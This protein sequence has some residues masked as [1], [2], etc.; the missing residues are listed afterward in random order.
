MANEF[1]ARKGIISLDSIQVSGS[2]S[3]TGGITISGSISS[4][5]FATTSATASSADNF[6]VRQNL[7]ASSAL[8]TGSITA[9]TLVVQTVTSSIVYSSGSNTFGNQLTNVQ[10]FTGSLRVTGSTTLNGNAAIGLNPSSA[11][12]RTLEINSSGNS[13][14]SNTTSQILLTGNAY[15]GSGGWTY[16]STAAASYYQQNLGAHSWFIAPSGTAGA[17]T[18]FTQSMTLDSSGKLGIG[19]SSPYASLQVNGPNT[20]ASLTVGTAANAVFAMAAGQELAITA[21]ASSPYGINFQARNSVAGGGPSG[22]SY[23][24]IFNPLGGNVGIGTPSPNGKLDVS[25]SLGNF[26]VGT[27]G[28]ELFFTRNENN[29]FLANAGSSAGIRLGAQSYLRFDTGTTLTERM[30]I[31]SGGY[32]GIGTTSPN[33]SAGAVGS[34]V[35]TLA[36]TSTGRNA[37]IELNGCRVN[38][39]DFIGYLRFFNNT[40]ATPGAEIYALRGASDVSGSLGFATSGTEVVRI[41][42]TGNVGIGT[43]SP[44]NGKL[45]IQQS[46]TT[47]GLWV[48]TGGTTTSYTV[49]DFRTGTNLSAL[50]ILGNGVS[51][52]GSNVAINTTGSAWGNPTTGRVLQIGTV[53]ALFT[54]NNT[55]TDLAYNHYFDGAD[56][57]Y[58][59]TDGASMFRQVSGDFVF[60]NTGSGA[61][62]AVANFTEKVRITCGG[63]VVIGQP[64][65][66][67]VLTVCAEGRGSAALRLKASATYAAISIGGTGALVVDYPGVSAG[68]MNLTDDGYLYLPRIRSGAGTYA[69]KWGSGGGEITY[70]TSSERYKNNIRDSIY[71]LCHVMRLNSKMF[72]YKDSNRT[73][74]GLIAEEVYPVIPELVILDD[75]CLPNA[76]S[77]DRFISVLVKAVQELKCENDIFKTCLGIG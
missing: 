30:R 77:Y 3:A 7:T 45:E 76:V 65:P 14:A 32:V 49:A 2:I 66:E 4:A 24:I 28:A 60:Y 37:I 43:S 61:A 68:R 13:L 50:Q 73:D 8:F 62:G 58:Q 46:A 75:N 22:T 67:A 51:S 31:T 19:T 11:T 17:V 52:F 20:N 57:R 21:N 39:G 44:T 71:G 41:T 42:C 34:T 56:Y 29:D 16:G 59:K 23:P 1:I 18:N 53:S 5:S 26:Y 36:A 9:Q 64:T 55:T 54:Y 27:S 72:E 35:L 6:F 38:S 48:Q 33:I 70:D 10:Q 40:A 63:S 15:Y 74:V 69:L 25:G 47:A 12:I